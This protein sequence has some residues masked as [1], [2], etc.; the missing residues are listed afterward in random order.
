MISQARLKEIVE[1]NPETG[2]FII[3]DHQNPPN[4]KFKTPHRKSG[5]KLQCKSKHNGKYYFVGRFD[6]RLYRLHRIAFLYM[7]GLMPKIIDHIDGNG[8]NNKWSNLR[9]CSQSENM[10]NQKLSKLS[11]YGFKG[12][13]LSKEKK[14]YRANIVLNYKQKHLGYF[15][16]PEEAYAAYCAAAKELHGEFAR[17]K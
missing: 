10:R 5:Y 13:S 14:K 8:L 11:K 3:R 1:Y 7:T 15:N 2:D 4:V 16:T 12:V 6:G 9:S 17:L